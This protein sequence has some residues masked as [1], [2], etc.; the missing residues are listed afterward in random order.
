MTAETTW[1][2]VFSDLEPLPPSAAWSARA[3]YAGL[4]LLR[5]GFRHCFAI[6]PAE[7]FAGWIVANPGGGGLD[8][9][10]LRAD[11][12]LPAPDGQVWLAQE[13][14]HG[15]TVAAGQGTV[16]L[17]RARARR[18]TQFRPRGPLT[19]VSCIK[20]LLGHQSPALTPYA[21]YRSLKAQ[22]T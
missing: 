4:R 11:Q 6:R 20:H 21:L 8:I 10:D 9:L 19:C 18:R 16:H 14:V 12:A 5:P 13:W 17:V 1:T 22:E 7:A 15:L 3:L 2:I